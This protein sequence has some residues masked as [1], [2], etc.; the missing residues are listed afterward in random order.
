MKAI[1]H[2]LIAI[3]LMAY[4]FYN[5]FTIEIFSGIHT[6]AMLIGICYSVFVYT[7]Y[8]DITKN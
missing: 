7:V 2:H 5:V 6:I 1:L 3:S 4:T 8:W